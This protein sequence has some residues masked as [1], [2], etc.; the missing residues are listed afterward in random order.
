MSVKENLYNNVERLKNEIE[1]ISEFIFEHAELGNE[2]YVSSAYL[3]EKLRDYGFKV[4]Y[5]Y[6][7]IPTAFTPFSG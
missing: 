2:E 5:P 7:D 3:V 6:L 4:T 1:N